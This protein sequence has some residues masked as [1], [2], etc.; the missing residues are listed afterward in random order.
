MEHFVWL[1]TIRVQGFSQLDET[2]TVG[3]IIKNST[4]SLTL[5]AEPSARHIQD[6][7]CQRGK[8]PENL[9]LDVTQQL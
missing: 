6:T 4:V 5:E 1:L 8:V 9:D 7:L 3:P 2:V